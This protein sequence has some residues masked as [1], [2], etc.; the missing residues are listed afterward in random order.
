MIEFKSSIDSF[1]DLKSQ[2]WCCEFTLDAIENASKE[3]DFM[4]H[5]EELYFMSGEELPTM[6]ELNDYIRFDYDD[7]FEA[8]GLDEDG[9][10]TE[11]EEEED[12]A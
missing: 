7:I 3:S 5:L 8:L 6:T 4:S 2:T 11:E 1:E 10:E 12:E 9:N